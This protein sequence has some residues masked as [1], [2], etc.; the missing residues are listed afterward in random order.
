LG[1]NTLGYLSP[2]NGE[3]V[4]YAGTGYQNSMV[5]LSRQIPSTGSATDVI[6]DTGGAPIAQRVGT[7]SKQEL[8]SDALGS[9][10]AMADD[11]A[12]TISRHYTYDP[13]GN[14]SA[15]GSGAITNL[16]FAGGHQ[17]G[18]LYHYGARYYDPATATWTQQDPIN[19]ISSLAGA[20][21]Y[22]YADGNPLD[23]ADPN[24]QLI[25]KLL[26]K[27]GDYLGA[28]ERFIFSDKLR[29]RA[30]VGNALTFGS[31]AFV[32]YDIADYSNQCA[33]NLTGGDL[34]GHN[35]GSCNPVSLV[36]PFSLP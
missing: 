26:D 31:K 13:D 33:N 3:L 2:G 27:A 14:A 10:I 24:G 18:N 35:N 29:R 22:A 9:T 1:A 16:L 7:T 23:D 34:E 28:G 6:R 15:T 36:N 12:N 11:S 25:D 30:T 21:H 20:N 8:F 5:G 19:Q 17:V 32:A 4:S